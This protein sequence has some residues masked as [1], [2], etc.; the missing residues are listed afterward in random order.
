L[1]LVIASI[2]IDDGSMK[3]F[4][5]LLKCGILEVICGNN[6]NTQL[7]HGMLPSLENSV[8]YQSDEGSILSVSELPTSTLT[9]PS[10]TEKASKNK[11]KRQESL[12]P[13]VQ[14][15]RASQ[16]LI[17]AGGSSSDKSMN[18][19]LEV[20]MIL[21]LQELYYSRLSLLAWTIRLGNIKIC[22]YL[23]KKFSIYY[24]YHSSSL[25]EQKYQKQHY[26]LL[27]YLSI[28]GNAEMI[29]AIFS[30]IHSVN[31]Q[32]DSSSSEIPHPPPGLAIEKKKIFLRYEYHN[33]QNETPSMLASKH[34][35]FSMIK[36]YYQLKVNL[37]KALDGRYA[38]WVLAFV[39]RLE[40]QEILTQTGR[41]GKDDELYFNL[42]N[43]KYCKQFPI[44]T[45][46]QNK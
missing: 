32:F 24:H 41:Y 23:L 33:K 17:P 40:N 45:I 37:R 46:W 27:H 9:N 22:S 8:G 31:N 16:P 11:T 10:A 13:A 14:G 42:Q 35:N 29:D 26:P 1:F 12:N 18:I 38:G 43:N 2:K 15:I 19:V 6:V 28:Y 36:K 4:I 20:P 30:V 7:S 39:E 21:K 5:Y 25:E 44:Y 3:M 34:S